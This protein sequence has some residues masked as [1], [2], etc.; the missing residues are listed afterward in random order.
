MSKRGFDL[1]MNRSNHG[2]HRVTNQLVDEL[3]DNFFFPP[4]PA[5]Y[6][7][8]FKRERLR[9]ILPT[10]TDESTEA[11]EPTEVA[12]NTAVEKFAALEDA[13]VKTV[14][15]LADIGAGLKEITGW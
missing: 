15:S 8:G 5:D 13:G 4:K 10:P 7:D 11:P 1:M 2:I 14:R 6:Y 12:D 9:S 3:A